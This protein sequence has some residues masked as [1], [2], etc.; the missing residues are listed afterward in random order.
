MKPEVLQKLVT[1]Q[2]LLESLIL[3]WLKDLLAAEM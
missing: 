1:N 3:R 2:L